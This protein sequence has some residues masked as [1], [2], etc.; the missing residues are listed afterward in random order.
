MESSI[1]QNA[2]QGAITTPTTRRGYCDHARHVVFVVVDVQS[3]WAVEEL[4]LSVSLRLWSVP[5][6]LLTSSISSLSPLS[7]LI[8][9]SG[10]PIT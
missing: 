1:S 10:L 2:A 4:L 3:E 5:F 9:P 6:S 8:K 7:P